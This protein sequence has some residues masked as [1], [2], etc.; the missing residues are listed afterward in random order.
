VQFLEAKTTYDRWK[1]EVQLI[2]AEA[3]RTRSYFAWMAGVWRQRATLDPSPGARSHAISMA[4][5]YIEL[6][7]SVGL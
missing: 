2:Y 3:G 5:L 7:G 6:E 4:E 1:E